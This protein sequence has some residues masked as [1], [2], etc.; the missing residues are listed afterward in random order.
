[1]ARNSESHW[2]F[3]FM[4]TG[5]LVILTTINYIMKKHNQ[6]LGWPPNTWSD[7][8]FHFVLGYQIVNFRILV[9]PFKRALGLFLLLQILD[10]LQYFILPKTFSALYLWKSN[11]NEITGDHPNENYEVNMWDKYCKISRICNNKKRPSALLKG[12]TNMRKLTIW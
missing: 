3:F 12:T 2:I 6:L 5:W 1:M 10:I 11:L 9:V 7:A 8:A 4:L